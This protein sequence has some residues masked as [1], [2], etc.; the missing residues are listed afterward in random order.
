[1]PFVGTE[2]FTPSASFWVWWSW[3]KGWIPTSRTELCRFGGCTDQC[4]RGCCG[5]GLE[6]FRRGSSPVVGHGTA[7][8]NATAGTEGRTKQ[9]PSEASAHPRIARKCT[10]SLWHLRDCAKATGDLVIVF[11]RE[12]WGEVWRWIGFATISPISCESFSTLQSWGHLSIRSTAALYVA[13]HW[14]WSL[15][16]AVALDGLVGRR[17]SGPGGR[18]QV[19]VA[20]FVAE[21]AGTCHLCWNLLTVFGAKYATRASL[22]GIEKGTGR[23]DCINWV[24]WE[25]C[26]NASGFKGCLLLTAFGKRAPKRLAPVLHLWLSTI[27]EMQACIGRG[28]KRKAE[29]GLNDQLSAG[30]NVHQCPQHT[31]CR[32]GTFSDYSGLSRPDPKR[33]STIN[34]SSPNIHSRFSDPVSIDCGAFP[35]LHVYHSLFAHDFYP[36]EAW[37]EEIHAK[38]TKVR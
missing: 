23:R 11:R 20:S 35:A 32:L 16:W 12:L 29:W 9:C 28:E 13:T 2:R 19:T 34:E 3:R 21:V 24:G 17:F 27:P 7:A 8:G 37:C 1:M 33:W 31:F 26:R 5:T 18:K 4:C 22:K 38:L 15:L 36:H 30:S 6:A 10:M 25:F 14:R